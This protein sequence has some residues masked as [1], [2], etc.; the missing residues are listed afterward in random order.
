MTVQVP[1]LKALAIQHRLKGAQ[2]AKVFGVSQA[3]MSRWLLGQAAVP[4]EHMIRLS[5][6]LECDLAVIIKAPQ[7]K[8]SANGRQAPTG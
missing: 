7:A 5:E 4:H 6:T 8:E 3:T 2:L 1:I